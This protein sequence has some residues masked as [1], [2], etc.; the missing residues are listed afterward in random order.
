MKQTRVQAIEAQS[1][2]FESLDETRKR[3]AALHTSF[4]N[5]NIAIF[6]LGN[7][8]FLLY[9]KPCERITTIG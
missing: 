5:C 8:K 7:G 4:G 9:W 3:C 1:E 6:K 2:T